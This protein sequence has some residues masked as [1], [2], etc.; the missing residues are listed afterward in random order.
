MYIHPLVAKLGYSAGIGLAVGITLIA[1]DSREPTHIKIR[2]LSLP[3]IA[4]MTL[5]MAHYFA[6]LTTAVGILVGAAIGI[7]GVDSSHWGTLFQGMAIG[8]ATG[9]AASFLPFNAAVIR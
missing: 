8:G 7:W 1:L 3:L 2:L 5:A 6:G 4:S 9:F